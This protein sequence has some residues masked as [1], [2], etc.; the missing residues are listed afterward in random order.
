MSVVY[1]IRVAERGDLDGIL[2]LQSTCTQVLNWSEGLW[3]HLLQDTAASVGLRG[4][5]VAVIESEVVG[6]AVLGGAAEFAELEMVVVAAGVREQ[7]I[8]RAFCQEAMYWA[9]KRGAATMELEVRTSNRA[10]LALYESLGFARQGVRQEYYREPV[11]DAVLMA[12]VLQ[13]REL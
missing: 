6:F 8:G 2:K 13:T 9:A 3:Q 1:T 10:A 11:E 4:I 7:G 5:W 12:C